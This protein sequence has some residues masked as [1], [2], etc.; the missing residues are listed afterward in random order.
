MTKWSPSCSLFNPVVFI[1]AILRWTCVKEKQRSCHSEHQ[2]RAP[3]HHLALHH[4]PPHNKLFIFGMAGNQ[5]AACLCVVCEQWR[6][7]NRLAEKFFS[8]CVFFCLNCKE[9]V[10][11][12]KEKI[13]K[14]SSFSALVKDC[15]LHGF[16]C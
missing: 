10:R 7:F 13:M 16:G 5:T 3:T 8:E 1:C 14:L 11:E 12:H 15:K 2:A 6:G 4:L 9:T